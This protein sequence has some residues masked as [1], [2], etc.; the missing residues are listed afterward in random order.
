MFILIFIGW[1]I[2]INKDLSINS[3][4]MN[5]LIEIIMNH[6]IILGKKNFSLD[7]T[8]VIYI[9]KINIPPII[10]RNKMYENQ[11]VLI[12]NPQ[13]NEIVN[14]WARTIILIVTGWVINISKIA[15]TNLTNN[16][17]FIQGIV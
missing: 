8:F 3:L 17:N 15:I 13:I 1:S 9:N 2:K 4:N 5:N 7:A 11:N 14:V 10:T 6:G 16:I 12:I